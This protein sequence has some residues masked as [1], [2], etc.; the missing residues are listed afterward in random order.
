[1]I[2][3][4]LAE[5]QNMV[6]SALVKLLNLEP[7]LSVVERV[8]TGPEIVP[9]AL[10]CQ[11]DVAVLDIELPGCSGLDAAEQLHR[12]LP[13]CRIMMITVFGRP[14]YL[15]RAVAAGATGFLVKDRPVDELATA[16]RQVAASETVLDPELAA[17]AMRLGRTLLS[18]REREILILAG[19]GAPVA[20]IAATIY[21]SEKTV[22]NHLSS[23]IGKTGTKN[24]FEAAQ[25]ARQ[26][27]WL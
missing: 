8:C 9:A 25:L 19:T 3:I 20:D 24:R 13:D 18:S 15:Q 27:G 5:D 6:G 17:A 10:R 11:P 7:G 21:L 1:M 16:I 23:A 26:N 4:L 12:Q 14:G 2:R 22:R